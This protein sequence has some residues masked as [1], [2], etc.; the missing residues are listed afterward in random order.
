VLDAIGS[1]HRR[2]CEAEAELLE[3]VGRLDP[4]RG[5]EHEGADSAAHWL[6]MTLGI[7]AW[8][9][10]RL[11]AATGALKVLPRTASAL[12]EGALSLDKTVELA[13]FA[14]PAGG[15]CA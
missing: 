3:L 9:A 13:R 6:A 1:V 12:R 4:E 7:S 8:K 15:R 2:I 5:W 10:H 14:D 11:V